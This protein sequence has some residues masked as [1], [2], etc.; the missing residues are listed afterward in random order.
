MKRKA[1]LVILIAFLLMSTLYQFSCASTPT[2]LPPTTVTTIQTVTVPTTQTVA[3]TPSPSLITVPPPTTYTNPITPPVISQIADN[4]NPHFFAGQDV[5][6]YTKTVNVDGTT[7]QTPI[8]KDLYLDLEMG[9]FFTQKDAIFIPKIS[10]VTEYDAWILNFTIPTFKLPILVNWGYI[11]NNPQSPL[12]LTN[13]E[14]GNFKTLYTTNQSLLLTG[15]GLAVDDLISTNGV[16]L[17]HINQQGNL[18]AFVRVTNAS[19]IQGWWMKFG[20]NKFN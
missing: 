7:T 8:V 2:A 4:N 20:G 3:V 11:P 1:L 5:S 12:S 13:W 18:I 19:D 9:G 10:G 17:S 15:K 16:H 14:R 6:G